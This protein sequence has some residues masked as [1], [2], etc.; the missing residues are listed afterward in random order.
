[1]DKRNK[2]ITRTSALN[3]AANILLACFKAVVGLLSHSIAITL[4]AV[5]NF[6]D[7]LSSIVTIAG[8]KF[9]NRA[10]DKNH[11]MGHG[12]FEYLAAS[13]IAIIISY[14]GFTAL[15]ESIQ[16]IIHPTEPDY[17]I[18]T[19]IVV[20]AAILVKILLGL[21]VEKVGERTKSD[22]LKNSG[23]DALMDSM[24]STGT[25][26]AI[27][28]FYTLHISIEPYVATLIS[29][30]II[31]SGIKMIADAF[32]VI[33][34]ERTDSKTS[35]AIKRTVASID[36]VMGAYDLIVH[37]YGHQ[38]AF[39]SIN[40]EVDNSLSA[41]DIDDLSRH[42]RKKVYTMHHVLITSVGIY[43]INKDDPETNRVY[44]QVK[45]IVMQFKHVKSIHGFNIDKKD[46]EISF[47][48][49]V[50]FGNTSGY[51]KTIIQTLKEYYPDYRF[52]ISIDADFSD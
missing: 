34:G 40:I 4:D 10:P 31:Y 29:L 24:I 26:I 6:S 28:I 3:I 36:G 32:S 16:K 15:I 25:L 7:M 23:R 38:R 17:S 42:I 45:E 48:V 14:I 51:H 27:I 19:V 11:P 39:A 37:D 22:M 1:M 5:N 2:Q 44:D 13:I 35:R 52:N 43:S 20:V 9:A 21:Y 33:L 18:A 50:D 49:V 41:S 30:F 46:K 12:R 47:D 8:L